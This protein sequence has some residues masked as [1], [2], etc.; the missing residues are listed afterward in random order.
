M[1][2][3]TAITAGFSG[4]SLGVIAIVAGIGLGAELTLITAGGLLMVLSVFGFVLG[5]LEDD[6]VGG[7]AGL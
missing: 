1:D 7:S 6:V 5:A 4:L 2:D 3:S